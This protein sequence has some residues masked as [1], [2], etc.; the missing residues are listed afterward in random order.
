MD[1]VK[2]RREKVWCVVYLLVQCR[3]VKIISID[4]THFAASATS[5]KE[6]EKDLL[7]FFEFMLQVQIST[8][9]FCECKTR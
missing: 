2:F 8:I 3:V 6:T 1:S 9:Q 7:D 5:C 4:L